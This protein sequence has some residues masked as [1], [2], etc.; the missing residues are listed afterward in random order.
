MQDIISGIWKGGKLFQECKIQKHLNLPNNAWIHI[1]LIGSSKI[2][3]SSSQN[4]ST[5]SLIKETKTFTSKLINVMLR[6][7]LLLSING[8]WKVLNMNGHTL[9][10]NFQEV[11]ISQRE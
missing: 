7:L 9:M 8:I 5:F 10:D 6:E 4:L 2:W 1:R 11:S 3:I